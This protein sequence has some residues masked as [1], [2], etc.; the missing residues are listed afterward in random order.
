MG[1][2]TK[3]I[4][5]LMMNGAALLGILQALV[6]IVKELLTLLVDIISLIGTIEWA[7]KLIDKIRAICNKID[8]TIEWMKGKLI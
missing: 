1:L 2:I 5:W 8:D 3:V 6:K 7:Q 4:K